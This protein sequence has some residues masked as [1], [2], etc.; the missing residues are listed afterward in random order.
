MDAEK[1]VQ[2]LRNDT[3]EVAHLRSFYLAGDKLLKEI[4]SKERN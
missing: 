3:N 4:R 1:Y 2:R